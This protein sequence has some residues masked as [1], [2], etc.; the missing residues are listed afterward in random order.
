MGEKMRIKLS[1]LA[2]L[3]VLSGCARYDAARQ[4]QDEAGGMPNQWM[5]VFGAVGGLANTQTPEFKA[6][7]ASVDA[8]MARYDAS[9]AAH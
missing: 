2:L 6:Y 5:G 4:C 1:I 7:A 3:V 9:V 8:C